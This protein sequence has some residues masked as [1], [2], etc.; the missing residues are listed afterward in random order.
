MDS[1]T[2]L[3]RVVYNQTII[4]QQHTYRRRRPRTAGRRACWRTRRSYRPAG[5]TTA[6]A[7]VLCGTFGLAVAAAAM[8]RH[9]P[10]WRWPRYMFGT[11]PMLTGSVATVVKQ[12]EIDAIICSG[13]VRSRRRGWRT[14]GRTG[15]RMRDTAWRRTEKRL[16]PDAYVSRVYRRAS[17]LN[18]EFVCVCA[19][20][21]VIRR[22]VCRYSDVLMCTDDDAW[23]KVSLYHTRVHY[24]GGVL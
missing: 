23:N 21:A 5:A 16:P 10:R 18:L 6:E 3:N 22:Y 8:V 7:A 4:R 24:T 20:L 11:T 13:R 12:R 1:V 2:E 17:A 15:G 9:R 14:D 19:R